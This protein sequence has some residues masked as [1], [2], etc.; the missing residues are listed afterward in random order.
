MSTFENAHF[1]KACM[2]FILLTH[3]LITETS[4][5]EITNAKKKFYSILYLLQSLQLTKK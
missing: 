1:L 4:E 2:S 5:N 3:A